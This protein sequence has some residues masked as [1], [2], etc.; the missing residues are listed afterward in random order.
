MVT[1]LFICTFLILFFLSEDFRD[2]LGGIWYSLT[3][4]AGPIIV[5]LMFCA[6]ILFG[7]IGAIGHHR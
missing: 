6:V 7:I 2:L 1:A 3:R 4:N 5:S